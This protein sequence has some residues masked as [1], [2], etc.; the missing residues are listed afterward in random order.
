MKLPGNFRGKKKG[1]FIL[2]KT[3]VLCT[4]FLII[5]YS[6]S[7]NFSNEETEKPKNLKKTEEY[8]LEPE[9]KALAS[10]Y[11]KEFHRKRMADGGIFDMYKISVAHR[12]LP[13]GTILK[14]T[15][16][17]NFRVIRAEVKDRGPYVEG[18]ELDLSFK[19]ASLLGAVKKGLIPV[20]IEIIGFS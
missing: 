2:H 10:W 6:P 12:D 20:K 9:W 16:L 18:R 17:E 4:M 14:I 19:A 13:F 15:N 11:G 3:M 7:H 1:G 5:F 8:H